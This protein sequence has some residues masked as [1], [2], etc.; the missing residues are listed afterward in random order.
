MYLSTIHMY[1][2]VCVCMYVYVYVYVQK[3]IKT[4]SI[5]LKGGAQ[6]LSISPDGKEVLVG[7]TNVC[8]VHYHTYTY[9]F[10]FTY[11]HTYAY[12]YTYT[13]TH[14]TC[15]SYTHTHR[16]I[17]HSFITFAYAY[18]HQTTMHPNTCARTNPHT[19][20]HTHTH[21]L[22]AY[23]YRVLLGKRASESKSKQFSVNRQVSH[24][25]VHLQSKS[26]VFASNTKK[27]VP[28]KA[29]SLLLFQVCRLC[30]HSLCRSAFFQ[31]LIYNTLLILRLECSSVC[32]CV[33]VCVYECVCVYIRITVPRL[34]L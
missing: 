10:T 1:A 26:Q 19:H 13:H 24:K 16:C 4:D 33:C 29:K 5:S 12:I 34:M 14:R 20:P 27:S 9:T 21:T 31:M 8:D 3:H 23:I 6:A 7:T 2:C 11:N 17:V 22:K 25:P 18:T 15:V 30:G 32:V 28:K